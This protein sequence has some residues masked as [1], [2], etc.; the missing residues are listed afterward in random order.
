MD[1][2]YPNGLKSV[3]TIFAVPTELLYFTE[4]SAR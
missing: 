1:R 3:A 2:Y 4:P